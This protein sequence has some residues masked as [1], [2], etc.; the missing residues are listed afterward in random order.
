[1]TWQHTAVLIALL[2]MLVVCGRSNTCS[3]VNFHELSALAQL[4]AVGV[5]GHAG[6][7]NRRKARMKK[8]RHLKL[9]RKDPQP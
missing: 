3:A 4:V 5:I 7:A 1:V 9:V 2:V 8:K 6:H